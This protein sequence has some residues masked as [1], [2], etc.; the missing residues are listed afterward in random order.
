MFYRE[1]RPYAYKW[2]M[3]GKIAQ[4]FQTNMLIRQSCM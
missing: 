1:A 4:S 3:S 2:E